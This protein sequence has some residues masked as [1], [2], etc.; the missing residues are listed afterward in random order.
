MKPTLQGYRITSPGVKQPGS[1]VFHSPLARKLRMSGAIP[2][3]SPYAFMAWTGKLHL[4][5]FILNAVFM[6][7]KGKFKCVDEFCCGDCF[8]L[9][10][11]A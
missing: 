6:P 3:L 2:L 5:T 8:G 11:C 10:L 4:F 1:N 9:F 7:S